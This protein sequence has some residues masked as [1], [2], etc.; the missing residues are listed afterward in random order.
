ML[1]FELF[2]A[3][4]PEVSEAYLF[5]SNIPNMKTVQHFFREIEDLVF[6]P[7]F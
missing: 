6:A 1:G 7:G 2:S 4:Q 5:L 3:F